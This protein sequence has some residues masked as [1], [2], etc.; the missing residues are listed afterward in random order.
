MDTMIKE[1]GFTFKELEK[2]IFQRSCEASRKYTKELLEEYDR[3]LMEK[4]DKRYYRHKGKRKT[5]IKTIYGEVE[6]HRAI[7]EIQKPEV[8]KRY[9][10][11]LDETLELENIGTI[12]TYLTEHLVS[13]ITEMSYRECAKKVSEMTGQSI[14]AMGVWNVI[15]SLGKKVDEEEKK[16]VK[17]HKAGTVTGEKEA[18][19]LF[20]EADGVYLNLQGR[21]RK[22]QGHRRAE[23]KV[24][25][26]YAGWKKTGKERYALEG[27]VI[28]AGFTDAKDFHERREAA[29]AKEYNLAETD[30]RLLNAD[31]ASWIRKVKDKSTHYQLDPFH[32]NKAVKENI[33]HREAARRVQEL[34]NKNAIEE[35]FSYLRIYKDSLSDDQE[36]EKVEGLYKYFTNNKE[37]LIPY[38]ERG[39]NLP[40]NPDG[41]EYRSMG[42][43][44]NHVWSVI[45][46]RMKH[47]HTSWSRAGGNNLSKILSK[48]CCGRLSEVTERIKKPI[49]SVDVVNESEEKIILSG[50]MPTKSGKG[51]EYPL[52]GHMVGLEMALRG[53]RKKMWSM[54]GY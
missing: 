14:S 3:Q 29:I 4:R 22:K 33:P 35:M 20:E 9:V 12:S 17:A 38:Q 45:A 24:A 30:V 50:S 2:I 6:Y 1:N 32:K 40:A 16:L 49:F 53:E 28:T 5:T 42:T 47:N 10:Y 43:M 52:M 54:A 21:D 51:Y 13:G 11:L 44:E 23:M 15:Q 26:A 27:K 46:K 19:V 41:L 18:P 37:G 8:G 36:I 31:G 34:L 39:I 25:I 48:K 7:Y